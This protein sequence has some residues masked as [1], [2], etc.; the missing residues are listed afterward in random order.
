M[1]LDTSRLEGSLPRAN[2]MASGDAADA[3]SDQFNR[4][5]LLIG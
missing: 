4:S 3:G 1:E 5:Q 2:T